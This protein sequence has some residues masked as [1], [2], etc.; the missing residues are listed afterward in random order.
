MVAAGFG[1]GVCSCDG[2]VSQDAESW[3]GEIPPNEIVSGGQARQPT[4]DH[5]YVDSLI[6]PY[7]PCRLDIRSSTRPSAEPR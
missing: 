5:D 4:A 1:H 3:D 7:R 2:W 6:V